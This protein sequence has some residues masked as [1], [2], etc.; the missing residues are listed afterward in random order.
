MAAST[1]SMQLLNQVNDILGDSTDK[2]PEIL[3][4]LPDIFGRGSQLSYQTNT[5]LCI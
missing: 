3:L 4:S 1:K 5:R 2:A